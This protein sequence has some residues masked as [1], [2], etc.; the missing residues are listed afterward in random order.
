[1]LGSLTD[2]LIELLFVVPCVLFALTIHEV[3][4]GYMAYRLGDPTARNMGRL[5]LNPM[6]HLD[7]FGTICM[8]LFHFGWARPVPINTR[9][10][11][12]PRRD[13]ALSAA[14][15][16]ISNF[17]MAFLGLLVQEIL[18]AIFVRHPATSQFAYNL[19]YAA[20]T[21]FSYFHILNL[22]LGMFNLIPVP[23]LDGSRIF[24]TFLPAKYYFGIMQY[25]RY[26]QL[27]LM[28]LLWLGFLD[29]PLSF[30]VS[31]LS[32]GMRFLVELLPFL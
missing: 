32:N 28:L 27:G 9:Y 18:F 6:K 21:L 30:L 19:Q 4:H 26:I 7:L 20:L 10:F 29:R 8:I 3:S 24:L 23:P 11:K 2:K 14:A 17:I 5:T 13:T 15:G 1:M 31:T 25:E 22:S 12:K 16:P